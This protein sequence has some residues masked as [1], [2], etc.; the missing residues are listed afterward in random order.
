MAIS[1]REVN[2]TVKHDFT[3][4]PIE[5]GS[6]EWF[7]VYELVS[8]K[9]YGYPTSPRAMYSRIDEQHE[10][11]PKRIVPGRGQGGMKAEFR[12]PDSVLDQIRAKF[13]ND[14]E[15]KITAARRSRERSRLEASMDRSRYLVIRDESGHEIDELV[16]VPRH[17]VKVSGGAGAVVSS[18]QIV[19]WLVFKAA[20][21][22]EMG[23]QSDRLVLVEAVGDS[24]L[25]TV[26]RGDLLLVDL[27]VNS[28][29]QEAVF[30]IRRDNTLQVKRLQQMFT[31]EIYIKSDNP[32]YTTEIVPN[33]RVADLQ[34]LGRVV[35]SGRKM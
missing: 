11:W 1:N 23:L 16:R 5:L 21:I 28:A 2:D 25:P 35:W 26:Q 33:E 31:G 20:W 34:I 6:R 19:D 29:S 18:E 24:M 27:R 7:G 13:S 9:L 12:P 4:N 10:N 17:D 32:S 15:E 8:F 22:R 3:D 14:W 30:V